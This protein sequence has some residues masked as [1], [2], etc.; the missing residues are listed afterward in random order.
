MRHSFR[1]TTA[2]VRGSPEAKKNTPKSCRLE[3]PV[4]DKKTAKTSCGKRRSKHPKKRSV[5]FGTVLVPV[6]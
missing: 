1:L 4:V 6:P 3:V 5:R 2:L